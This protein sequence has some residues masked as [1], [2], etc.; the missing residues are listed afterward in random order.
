[1]F[2]SYTTHIV[3]IM[4]IL[5]MRRYWVSRWIHAAL[6]RLW[7]QDANIES[8][9]KNIMRIYIITAT[10]LCSFSGNYHTLTCTHTYHY[11]FY[12]ISLHSVVRLS[13]W[14]VPVS[15]TLHNNHQRWRMSI[16]WQ[17]FGLIIIVYVECTVH[18]SIFYFIL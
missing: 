11:P 14:L 18:R 17:V 16:V 3:H 13:V 15:Y 1:M 8:N 10:P 7:I 5:I 12:K 6:R 4:I 9:I 2:L